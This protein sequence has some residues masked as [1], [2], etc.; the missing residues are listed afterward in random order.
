[1]NTYTRTNYLLKEVIF[2]AECV[3]VFFYIIKNRSCIWMSKILLS[4]QLLSSWKDYKMQLKWRYSAHNYRPSVTDFQSDF[5]LKFKC[6]FWISMGNAFLLQSFYLKILRVL[7]LIWLL[8]SVDDSCM[9]YC[10]LL[11]SF[12]P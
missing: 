6:T 8:A 1:M 11:I 10:T 7:R 3:S 5:S 2:H 9:L 4:T 12:F